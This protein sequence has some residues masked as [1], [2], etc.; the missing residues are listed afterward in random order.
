MIN[1]DLHSGSV[2][3]SGTGIQAELPA[4]RVALVSCKEL[5]NTRLAL[6]RLAVLLRARDVVDDGVRH[7]ETIILI[8]HSLSRGK[9]GVRRVQPRGT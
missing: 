2:L 5:L 4:Y 7:R 3:D 8:P 6:V 1:H 9:G